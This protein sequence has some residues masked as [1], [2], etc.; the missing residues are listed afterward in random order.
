MMFIAACVLIQEAAHFISVILVHVAV[1]QRHIHR[2]MDE[3]SPASL[4]STRPRVSFSSV[5]QRLKDDRKGLSEQVFG[6]EHTFVAVL[7]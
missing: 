3:E 4:P 6:K 1:C 5:V 2:V 7:E